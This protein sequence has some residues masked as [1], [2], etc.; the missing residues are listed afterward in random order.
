M[1]DTGRPARLPAAACAAPAAAQ[2]PL[3]ALRPDVLDPAG[4]ALWMS[5]GMLLSGCAVGLLLD[6]LVWTS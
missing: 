6:R 2:V 4:A 1:S 3:P 5:T